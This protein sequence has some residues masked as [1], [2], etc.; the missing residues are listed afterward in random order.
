[1]DYGKMNKILWGMKQKYPKDVI[2]I[3]FVDSDRFGDYLYIK[4]DKLRVPAKGKDKDTLWG[5]YDGNPMA[6]SERFIQSILR[7]E[8]LKNGI[9]IDFQLPEIDN[10]G[11]K[12]DMTYGGEPDWGDQKWF[13]I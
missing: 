13:L 9:D 2:D 10:K 7:P 6:K 12:K 4:Y 3:R 1:M 5:L 11:L 8:L